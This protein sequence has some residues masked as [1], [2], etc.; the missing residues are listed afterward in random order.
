M[1]QIFAHVKGIIACSHGV[2]FCV[3]LSHNYDYEGGV[4][5]Y[6]L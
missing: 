5:Y 3:E 1:Q 6:V 2:K 4:I